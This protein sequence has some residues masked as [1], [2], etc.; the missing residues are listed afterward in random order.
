MGAADGDTVFLVA[1]AEEAAVRVLGPL[2]LHLG[3]RLGLIEDGW[4]FV[5]VTDFPM[6]EW[7]PDE[8]RWKAATTRSRRP[9]RSSRTAS[10]TTRPPPAP[11]STTWC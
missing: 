11:T 1:D 7:L 5:W 10:P 2:R 8:N 6:F 4:Q 3:E 9:R